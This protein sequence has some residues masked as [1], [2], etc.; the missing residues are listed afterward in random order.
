MFDGPNWIDTD[1]DLRWFDLL[2]ID[3]MWANTGY[4]T[5]VETDNLLVSKKTIEPLITKKTKAIVVFH[6]GVNVVKI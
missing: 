2:Q 1:L 6:L 4:F 5:D 3:E